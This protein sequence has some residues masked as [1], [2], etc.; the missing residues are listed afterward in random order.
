MMSKH[1][2]H[3]RWLLAAAAL[4]ALA[5]AAIVIAVAQIVGALR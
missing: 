2:L 3:G 5:D 4:A 1:A